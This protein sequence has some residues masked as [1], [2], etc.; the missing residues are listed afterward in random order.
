MNERLPLKPSAWRLL[1]VLVM[2]AGLA[3]SAVSSWAWYAYT[4][5]Q[6][7]QASASSL[8]S[9]KSI[10]G[11]SLDRDTD[12]LATVSAD[13]AT[14]PELTNAS[15]AAILSELNLAQ[16]YPGSVAFTYVENVSRAGLARFDAVTER[17]PPL[18]VTTGKVLPAPSLDGRPGYCLTRLVAI[19][20]LPGQGLLKNLLLS[21]ISPYLSA[22]FNFCASSFESLLDTSARTGM[23]AASTVVG[24]VKARLPGMAAIPPVLLSFV[25]HYPIF[26]DLSPVYRGGRVPAAVKARTRALVGWT[27]GVFDA[28]EILNPAL[29]NERGISLTLTYTALGAEPTVL[30]HVGQPRPGA[31]VQ[32]LTFP[33]DPGWAIDVAM[34]PRAAGPSPAVQGLAVFFGALAVTLLLVGLLSQLVRSRRSALEL[35]EERTAELRHQALHDSLTG[36]PNRFFINEKAHELLG[37][38]HSEGL[39]IAVF[40]IDLDDFKKVNDTL[41]HN[42]GDDLLR[43]VAARLSASVRDC[44]TVGR[45]GGDEFVV[46]S[47]VPDEGLNVV[48]ERLLAILREP[49]MLG[50]TKTELSTSASIGIATGLYESPEELLRDA[51]T[52]MY[53]AKSTGKNCHVFFRREMHEALKNQ[54]TMDRELSD[55]FANKQFLLVYQPIVDL[56]TGLPNGFE[57]LLRWR[58]PEHGLVSA[59]D[60][61]PALESS[62][63]I[64][65]VGRFVLMEACHQAKAWNLLGQPV[66]V[67]VNVGA[68]QLHYDV[69][70]DHVREAL[71][72]AGLEPG[73]L[74]LEVTESMLMIDP[75]TTAR[76]LSVLSDLGVHIA[77]DDFG[78]GYASISYLREF[79][80]D[81]LKID[82]S[83]V[84]QL[85]TSTDTNLLDALIQLGKSLGLVTIAEGIEEM[86]QLRHLKHQG[87]EWGQ[88][89]LFSKPLPP[90][91][92]DHVITHAHYLVGDSLPSIKAIS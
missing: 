42:T 29:A 23:P 68:R 60:F 45:L 38:V 40:F 8:G 25:A 89:F 1:V 7:R 39:R 82:R 10:L 72:T 53:R 18:A 58:H 66:G 56:E 78:T 16:H 86:S 57:A 43:A 44:D 73:Y 61:I 62:G 27:L 75:K 24:L 92:I 90:V 46:L 74:T 14:N 37:R 21:W 65:D 30:A 22:A 70:I 81:I 71:E 49:F 20:L 48:A 79:P 69:L 77:I 12:L 51:D 13:L 17:D 33:A 54:L 3:V 59:A 67:A 15:L 55:A 80:V 6:G 83:F 31:A 36:L 47:E 19:E 84:S 11:T 26:I 32:K 2:L 35:V 64:V 34:S 41:G 9:V 87:C 28:D 91:E 4:S 85:A 63:L 52:A 88:G 5:S 76:H 50:D